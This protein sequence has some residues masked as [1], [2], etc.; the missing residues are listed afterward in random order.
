LR[1]LTFLVSEPSRSAKTVKKLRRSEMGS[2]VDERGGRVVLLC[3]CGAA[4]RRDGVGEPAPAVYNCSDPT[5]GDPSGRV[6]QPTAGPCG[7]R[8]VGRRGR[9]PFAAA[10]VD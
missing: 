6:R 10:D 5:A 7:G 2:G 8:V 1:E 4:R 9:L 3:S